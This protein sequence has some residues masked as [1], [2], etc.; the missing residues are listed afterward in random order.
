LTA[1]KELIE[2]LMN[3]K[4][5][6]K[7][8]IEEFLGDHKT[9]LPQYSPLGQKLKWDFRVV[10]KG[11]HQ[12]KQANPKVVWISNKECADCINTSLKLV[13]KYD[14]LFTRYWCKCYVCGNEFEYRV[15]QPVCSSN[16]IIRNGMDYTVEVTQKPPGRMIDDSVYGYDVEKRNITKL[17]LR[18]SYG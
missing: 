8:I 9:T 12:N 18:W 2:I 13:R 3:Q 6:H 7:S 14:G 15:K 4:Q 11:E 16:Y 17:G 10:C 5:I 1:I